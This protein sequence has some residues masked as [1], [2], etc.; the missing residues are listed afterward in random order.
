MTGSDKF[1]ICKI[2][3]PSMISFSRTKYIYI[4][5]S[6]TSREQLLLSCSSAS[7]SLEAILCFHY[8]FYCVDVT[9]YISTTAALPT[10]KVYFVVLIGD[11][12]CSFALNVPKKGTSGL[13]Q[14]NVGMLGSSYHPLG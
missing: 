10:D 6:K 1:S 13:I 5:I 4:Y 2:S 12:L 8:K 7:L 9:G 3:V 14:Y 11:L